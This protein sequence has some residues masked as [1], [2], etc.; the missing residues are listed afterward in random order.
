MDATPAGATAVLIGGLAANAYRQVPRFTGDADVLITGALR[1]A[2][3]IE[4]ALLGRGFVRPPGKR[5]YKVGRFSWR[6]LLWQGDDPLTPSVVDLFFGDDGFLADVTRRALSLLVAKR[7]ILVASPED[8]VL[9]KFLAIASGR[10]Q[11]G[12][13]IITDDDDVRVILSGLADEIDAPYLRA[14]AQNLG[15]LRLANRYL[16]DAGL[17]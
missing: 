7:R 11:R 10:E 15:V 17:S 16:R 13:K 3:V 12:H 8:I 2:A 6:R 9:F 14:Q 1:S 5:V 4:R